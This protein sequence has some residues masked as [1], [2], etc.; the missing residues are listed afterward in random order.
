MHPHWPLYLRAALT[1]HI[2]SG[3]VAFVCA[4]IALLTAKGG[5]THRLWGKIYFWAMAVVAATALFLSI[6]L[7]IV[8]LALVAV[9]S[10]YAA[11]S[12]YRILSLK[13]LGRD[14]KPHFIDWVAALV[15]LGASGALALMGALHPRLAGGMALVLVVLGI[16]GVLLA[17]SSLRI[18]LR[19]PADKQFWWFV[20][21]RGMIA[22]YI[23]AFTAFIVVNLTPHFGNV[24]WIWLAP[25]IIGVPGIILWRRYYQR[26][27][28][29][30]AAQPA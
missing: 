3:A 15:T 4:P 5:R 28:S 19:P 27:F 22:S 10:F 18:F 26:K 30:K 21:M 24:W 1:L 29:A 2:A 12:G 17:A 7:P 9:F 14:Q 20:H 23:A 6:V 8:F 11:F 13:Q 25:T 16:I